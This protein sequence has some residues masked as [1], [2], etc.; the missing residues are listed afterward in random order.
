[1]NYEE[2]KAIKRLARFGQEEEKQKFVN[3]C[4][5]GINDKLKAKDI[6]GAESIKAKYFLYLETLVNCYRGIFDEDE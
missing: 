4:L 2:Y 3:W 6:E 1:M 5:K